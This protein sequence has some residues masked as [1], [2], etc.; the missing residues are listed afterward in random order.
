MTYAALEHA[1]DARPWTEI[2]VM[3]DELATLP[4]FVR[5]RVART[6]RSALRWRPS[7]A[8]DAFSIHEQLWHLRD[9]DVLGYARRCRAIASEPGAF[10]ADID[11]TRLAV[12]R[13]YLELPIELAVVELER[14]RH[15]TL[16]FLRALPHAAYERRGEMEGVGCVSL[17]G[18]LE[19]WL[20][21]DRGHRGE[22][23]ELLA[24]ASAHESGA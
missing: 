13:R 12:E 20:A 9:I 7:P 10:L 4:A 21:H 23:D 16:E 17:P 22:I 18:L 8:P 14:A 5:E 24:R 1:T 19:M 6:S 11:G 2:A 3:L 15:E